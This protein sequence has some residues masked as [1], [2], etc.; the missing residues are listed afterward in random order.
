MGRR[1]RPSVR[2]RRRSSS[3]RPS[4]L[5]PPTPTQQP[6]SPSHRRHP[7][8]TSMT[9]PA[10]LPRHDTF[11]SDEAFTV[12]FYVR[13]L[14]PAD[15]SVSFRERSVRPPRP[16]LRLQPRARASVGRRQSSPE[17]KR[18]LPDRAVSLSCTPRPRFADAFPVLARLVPSSAVQA[19]RARRDVRRL[20]ARPRDRPGR[21]DVQGLQGQGRGRP[22]QA[23]CRAQVEPPAGRGGRDASVPPSCFGLC[24][25]LARRTLRST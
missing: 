17:R 1:Q 10:A 9:S 12:S 7:Q 2:L 3:V 6:R 22:P 19:D 23:G 4:S 13:N 18:Q 25:V 16:R 24:V 5:S 15:V 14:D 20:A 21:V 11:Q 8:L